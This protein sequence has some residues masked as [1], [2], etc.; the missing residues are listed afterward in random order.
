MKVRI[1]QTDDGRWWWVLDD[2]SPVPRDFGP[3]ASRKDAEGDARERFD[4]VAR[5]EIFRHMRRRA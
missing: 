4:E 5:A 1:E 3:F 2:G